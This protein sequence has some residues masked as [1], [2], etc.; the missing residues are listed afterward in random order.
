MNGRSK[1]EFQADPAD[2][3]MALARSLASSPNRHEGELDR[4]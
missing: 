2:R 1:V 4:P 3:P